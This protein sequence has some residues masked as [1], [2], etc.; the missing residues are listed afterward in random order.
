MMK[1]EIKISDKISEPYAIIYANAITPEIQQAV[2]ALDTGRG[3][4]TALAGGKIAVLQ[5]EEIV[6]LRV[7]GGEVAVYTAKSRF[8]VRKRL[9]EIA[10]RLGPDF[11]QIAKST[12]VNLRA[13]D[14]VEPYFN[15]M[16]ALKL[17]NGLSD[18]IS[19][20]YLPQF[21]QALGL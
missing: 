5:A 8:T 1:V 15:G 6:L 20:K 18:Y 13:I 16:M 10:E 21:K 4:I 2:A 9:Y 19:R 14:C 3:I 17:K 11:I 12:V 7:E